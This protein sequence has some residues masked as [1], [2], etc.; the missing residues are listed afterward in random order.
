MK[1]IAN[2]VTKFWSKGAPTIF[3]LFLGVGL[4]G[5]MLFFPLDLANNATCLYESIIRSDQ[6]V[7]VNLAQTIAGA[8]PGQ[9]IN[10]LSHEQL[11]RRINDSRFHNFRDVYLFWWWGS[12]GLLII[13]VY[14]LYKRRIQ[15][16]QSA[17]A[18]L[19]PK[20]GNQN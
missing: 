3:G 4:I 10:R 11:T 14:K 2:K 13:G 19:D 17:P 16:K 18:L 15:L 20:M 8:A 1:R 7:P 12:T 9:E 5:F 6:P